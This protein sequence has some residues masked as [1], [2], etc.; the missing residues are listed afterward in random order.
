M[1]KQQEQATNVNNTNSNVKK[2]SM[3]FQSTIDHQEKLQQQRQD[4][5]TRTRLSYLPRE[6][7]F[8]VV[9][10]FSG[11]GLTNHL[12]LERDDLVY[13]LKKSD[14]CGNSLNWFVDNGSRDS[15]IPHLI[16][17][18]LYFCC[19]ISRERFSSSEHFASACI[20]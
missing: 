7:L 4:D 10:H 6:N 20:K 15:N 2:Q 17:N 13:V 9:E 11:F 1:E 18:L 3:H 16:L 8:R 19:L 12:A 5:E 14:P